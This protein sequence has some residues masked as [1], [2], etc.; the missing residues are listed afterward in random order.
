MGGHS[1]GHLERRIADQRITI[2]KRLSERK[3]PVIQEYY[4]GSQRPELY[5]VSAVPQPGNSILSQL[6]LTPALIVDI[7]PLPSAR[8]VEIYGVDSDQ[9]YALADEGFIIPNIYH[10]KSDGWRDYLPYPSIV[11]LLVRYGRPN[12]E[13]IT[14]YL[15][16]AYGFAR[17]EERHTEFFNSVDLSSAE[18]DEVIAASHNR[19]N[20]WERFAP[21]YGQRLAYIEVLGGET[22][23]EVVQWIQEQYQHRVGRVK[24]IQVLNA[25]KHLIATETTAAY[26]G[27]ATYVPDNL[28]DISAS[29]AMIRELTPRKLKP[30]IA[31]PLAAYEFAEELSQRARRVRLPSFGMKE[32]PPTAPLSK[33]EFRKYKEILR[34]LRDGRL[35]RLVDEMTA[36]ISDQTSDLAP[37][38]DEY[39]EL[40]IELDSRLRPIAPVAAGLDRLGSFFLK[41]DKMEPPQDD[42]VSWWFFLG[43]Q[44]KLTAAALHEVEV[45]PLFHHGRPRRLYT[46]WKAVKRAIGL[47]RK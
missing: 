39:R 12:A 27:V 13:W 29:L 1:K 8:F 6:L 43:N 2:K 28:K 16:K 38:L 37:T 45:T 4:W 36:A 10:Y 34:S 40:A 14:A 23:A 42:F 26:G 31:V 44:V 33:A 41:V 11:N 20:R 47:T 32:H 24:A 18:R 5:G 3:T 22:F 46:E 9:M 15:E 21:I 35:G 30:P 7:L 19:V 25:S 17:V